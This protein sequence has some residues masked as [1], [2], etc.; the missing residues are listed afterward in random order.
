MSV[1][2]SFKTMLKYRLENLGSMHLILAFLVFNIF[3]YSA[4]KAQ[5]DSL[6]LYQKDKSVIVPRYPDSS[7][8]DKFKRDRDYNYEDNIEP[9]SNPIEKWINWL[10]RRIN[11]FFQSKSYN[12]VWQYVIMGLTILL[13]IYLLYKAK[14]LEYL[15]PPK[16]TGTHTDYIVGQENIHEINFDEA[17]GKA[18]AQHDY[19]LAIRLQYLKILKLLAGKEL[20]HWKPNLTNHRYVKELEKTPHHHDFVEITKYFEYTWYGDF[21]VRE[22]GYR[23]MKAFS[24]S[25]VEKISN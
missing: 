1:S 3:T 6:K 16:D 14:V 25:F 10:M 13:V 17:I 11:D 20:I 18:L 22:S 15:F 19:R 4:V 9:A 24:D 7:S 8:L 21:E 5:R 2:L 12:S 23:E